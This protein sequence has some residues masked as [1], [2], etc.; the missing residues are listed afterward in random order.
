MK[1]MKVTWTGIRPLVMSNPQ[2]VKLSNPYAIRSRELNA[3]LKKA[4]KKE[5]ADKLL[6]LE[7][8]QI[9]NDWESSAYWDEKQKQFYIPDSVII[10]CIRAGATAVKKGRD[11]DRAVLMS[12]TEAYIQTQSVKSLDDGFKNP[13]FRLECPCK[14]PPKTGALIWKARCMIPTGWKVTFTLEYDEE[15]FAEKTLVTAMESSGRTGV[16]GWRGKFGRFLVEAQ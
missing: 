15:I 2:T 7:Q 12:E 8:L 9:R 3:A 14:V 16:G 6:E 1:T 11:V 10:A 4:R 13:A 5:D